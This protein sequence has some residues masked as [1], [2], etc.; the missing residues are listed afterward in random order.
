LLSLIVIALVFVGALFFY[1]YFINWP[2]GTGPAGPAVNHAPF[3]NVWTSKKVLLLGL[4][5]SVTK[6]LGASE[7]FSYFQRLL[8]NP[9]NEYED[10][11]GICLSVVIPNIV[12]KNVA[13]SGSNSLHHM[14]TIR[15]LAGQ[16]P[17]TVGLVVITTGGNDLIHDYGRSPPCEGAMYGA[18]LEQ[19]QPWIEAFDRRLDEMVHVLAEKF[20]GG[21]HIF[22]ANIYDP[23]DASGSTEMS[24]LHFVFRTMPPWPDGPAIVKVY[25]KVIADCA[26]RYSF[27]H[28]IDMYSEFLGHGIHCRKFWRETYRSQDPH[29]WYLPILEDPNDRGYDAI[30]RLF[31]RKMA[32]ILPKEFATEPATLST[33]EIAQSTKPS[34]LQ[35]EQQQQP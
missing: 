8:S 35:E 26:E 3:Q 27:V 29:F 25:N 17:E 6:G 1:Y 34:L 30:R 2:V 28:L 31:L 21:C 23:S 20:P 13:V 15:A 5:D 24:M 9:N 4:G 18:S 7:G 19:A 10:M 11:K 14:Q 32:E 12:A 33:R 22:L 16:G